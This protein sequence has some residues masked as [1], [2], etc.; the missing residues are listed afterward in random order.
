MKTSFRTVPFIA[1]ILSVMCFVGLSASAQDAT[2]S[3][4]DVELQALE[5]TTPIPAS[6]VPESGTFWSAQHA[7]DWPPL[8]SGFL[9][10]PA[11]PLGDNVFVLDDLNVNYSAMAQ[12]ATRSRISSGIH[13]MDES[14]GGFSPDFSFPSN[15]LYL[16][17]NAVSNGLAYV[18]LMNA[19]DYVYEIFSKTDL[20][21]TNW[22]IEL[23]LWPTNT[24]SMPFTVSEQSRT[25]LFIWARDWTGITENGN[26]TPDWWFYEYFGTITLSDTNLDSQGNT[27]LYDYTNGLDPNI[28][29]FSLT[30]TNNYVNN[31]S[32]PVQLNVTAGVPSYFAVLVD[33][34]N[35]A[36]ATWNTY[37]SSSITANL[38]LNTGWHGV[39]VGLR[40]LPSNATQTWQW[41]RLN[42]LQPPVLAITNPVTNVVSQPM[43][44]I[45]GY[46]QDSLASINYD[47]SNAVGMVTNQPSEIT[48]RYFDTNVLGFTTNYFEC[49]DVP[50]TNGLNTITLHATDLAG[51]ITTTNFNFTLD[52]SGKTNPPAV[53]ITWPTNG[54]QISG[55]NFTWTGSVSDPTATVTGQA[56]DTNGDTNVVVGLV[57]RNGNFWVENLPLGSGTNT[58]TL[59]VS[60]VVG[61][62]SVTNINVIQS[63]LVLTINPVTPS[64]QLWQPTV[65]LTGTISDSTYAVWVNGVKGHNNGDGT[66]SANNVPTTSG[67][68]ASFTATAYSPTEQQPN[69]S[70][71][72]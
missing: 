42:L 25:N 38:G 37:T 62:T 18:N 12:A 31:M 23:E 71:G 51:D 4:F 69:G 48:D 11:W 5:A 58:L 19:T 30:V 24:T 27:L 49:L 15:S 22:N 54:T 2:P 47:I 3:D 35:F 32:A 63:S 8:P 6:Q 20:T 59:T 34:T 26:T 41:E 64:S 36:D 53:Q 70:Y 13:A 14:G 40:G 65:N 28:I 16:Q 56:V 66:W 44:Q 33:D 7:T 9:N 21:L 39:W 10:V 67:G 55:S 50:L 61:N 17:I 29:S 57:E 45:Y 60:D 68:T 43:I 52:Y 46:C 1:V 72:N